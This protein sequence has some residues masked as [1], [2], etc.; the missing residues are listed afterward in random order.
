M[1]KISLWVFGFGQ[2]MEFFTPY[3]LEKYDVYVFDRDGSKKERITQIWAT[4]TSFEAAAG[5]QHILLGY[6]AGSIAELCQK[7]APLVQ[8]DALIFDICSVKTPPAAAMLE[9]LPQS[10]TLIGTHPIFWPQSGKNGIQGL[11]M[12][13]SNIRARA[14]IFE[15]FKDF[16]SQSLFLHTIDIL[17]ED[18]DR[19]M[20]YVQGITHFIGRTLKKMHIPNTLLATQSYKHLRE[21]SE[22]VGYDSDDLFYSIQHDN[23]FAPEIRW[24]LL[25]QFRQLENWIITR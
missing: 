6:P 20:A 4:A 1:K 21:T 16:F 23:P 5:C 3:L 9:F 11:K 2:F 15:D 17:P 14:E 24:E 18:H 10:V 22:L 8:K 13:F 12:T 25:E 19:E 7:L